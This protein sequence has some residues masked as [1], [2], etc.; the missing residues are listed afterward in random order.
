[1]K[2]TVI[3]A[4][5][6]IGAKLVESLSGD[7]YDV[8]AAS[9]SS[10]VDVLTGDGLADA[11]SGAAALVDV[12]NS[13]SFE[14]GPVLEFFTKST[15]NLVS[16]AQRAGVGNYVC[17]SI[18]G[19]DDLPDSGYMR[20]KVAQEKIIIDSGLPYTIVR[21]TQFEE[22]TEA[23]TASMTDGDEV[24]VPDAL[25][26]PVPAWKVVSVVARAAVAPPL[27]GTVNIGGP[28]KISFA[29]MARAALAKQ[30]ADKTVVIDP[31]AKYFGTALRQRSLV[32]P[33]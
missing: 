28:E 14:D 15:S 18:V 11:L 16:A 33:D 4:S 12:V 23:I 13:P 24:R 19:A 9:R 20:A 32:T 30:G 27:R 8:V 1:M 10:G 5:G 25:I 21:A 22:F 6:L 29:D 17:L 7:G 2:V 31:A 26:Q 3:G